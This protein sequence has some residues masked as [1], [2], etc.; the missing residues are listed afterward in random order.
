MLRFSTLVWS[1]LLTAA[2]FTSQAHAQ[3]AGPFAA[4]E[5]RVVRAPAGQSLA[6]VSGD[7]VAQVAAYLRAAGHDD[8][9]VAS[10]VLAS[11]DTVAR[12][13]V[14][15]LR[16]TQ[17]VSGLDVYGTYLK[18]SVTATG[19]LASVVENVV[20][21]RAVGGPP[22][23]GGEGRALAIGLQH[24]HGGAPTPPGLVR[25]DGNTS[26]FARTAFF[27]REPTV[28]RVAV[29]VG[30]ALRRGYL[31]ETWTARGNQLH[32]TLVGGD[33][34]VLGVESR[35]ASDSYNVFAIDPSK[36][37]Q[38]VVNGPAPAVK[39]PSP[40]GWL[41]AGTQA[42]TNIAGNNVN[43]YVDANAN[44]AADGGGVAVSD[45]N[46]LATFAAGQ[47]PAVDPNK[48]VATQN[49]FYLNNVIHDV[50]Y[51]HGFTESA[52]N[53]QES[54]FGLTGAGSDS[55][56]AEVQDGSGTDNANFSTPADGSHPRM[57]MYIW[58]APGDTQVAIGSKVFT[59]QN[60]SFTPP[61]RPPR[62]SPACLPSS[63][64]ARARRRMPVSGSHAMHSSARSRSSTAAPATS[65]SR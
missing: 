10:L 4:P 25:Q 55:V 46:F 60:S 36:S 27:H 65:T 2:L 15:H 47:Q 26:V 49:L 61:S 31:V 62:A 32:H 63:T 30:A 1:G 13:G 58:S 45:G 48:A 38:L 57:Q 21:V 53:F 23:D 64:T 35:T 3:V 5:A 24:V 40:N 52:G 56:Y 20:T 42:T 59:A 18:A 51:R 17:R 22:L 37:Q 54:N 6:P 16:F 34:A 33:G 50:L 28:T 9:T 14:T 19:A 44:N 11:R 8:A 41:F 12:T 7:P 43:A 29:P 39:A